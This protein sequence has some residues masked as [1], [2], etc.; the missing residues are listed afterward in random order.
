MTPVPGWCSGDL[1]VALAL[2]GAARATRQRDWEKEALVV[3]RAAAAR[4]PATC[5][6]FDTGLCHGSAGVAHLLN[7]LHQATG[8][9]LF[10]EAARA[11]LRRLLGQRE[12]GG[13]GGF[14]VAQGRDPTR[15]TK[16]RVPGLLMGAAGIALVLLAAASD[17]EPEWD[18]VLLTSVRGQPLDHARDHN[19]EV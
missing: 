13:L 14:F 7:R 4:D 11:W 18:R 3:A 6:V 19:Y 1:G 17:I 2:L 10:A 5:G 8:E 12:P 9:A 16:Q 15:L